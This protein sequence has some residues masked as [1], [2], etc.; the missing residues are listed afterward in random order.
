MG[1]T[2]NKGGMCSQL[3]S[4]WTSAKSG[5]VYGGGGGGVYLPTPDSRDSLDRGWYSGKER[6][7]LS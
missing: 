6:E 4:G 2:G 1:L 7:G 5:Y 3:N